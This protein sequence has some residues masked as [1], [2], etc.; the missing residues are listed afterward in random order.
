L[1]DFVSPK[2][3]RYLEYCEYGEVFTITKPLPM[4]LPGNVV[5][6]QYAKYT[7][8][9]TGSLISASSSSTNASQSAGALT[10]A[11]TATLSLSPEVTDKESVTNGIL[12]PSPSTATIVGPTIGGVVGVLLIAAAIW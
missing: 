2:L 6:T 11:R 1:E 7:Y 9:F 12:G 10:S 3:G 5:T 8:N 4:T